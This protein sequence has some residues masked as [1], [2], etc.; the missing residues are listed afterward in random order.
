[1]KIIRQIALLAITTLSYVVCSGSS[2]KEVESAI[3]TLGAYDVELSITFRTEERE[4]VAQGRYSVDGERYHLLIEGQEVYGDSLIR[5]AVNHPLREV[6][7]EPLLTM[8]AIVPL[9][10]VNP[11]VAFTSLE[12]LFEVSHQGASTEGVERF[13]LT[14]RAE[15]GLFSRSILEVD[16]TTKLPLSVSYEG[17]GEDIVIHMQSIKSN[18]RL[19]PTPT[20]S[21]YPK[22]YKLFDLR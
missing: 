1:M 21:P 15:N 22:D 4:V 16:S 10:M 5:V 2:L 18:S 19:L 8:D 3:T 11:A 7:I 14:P 9:V 17:D 20:E 13:V 6:V 12:E